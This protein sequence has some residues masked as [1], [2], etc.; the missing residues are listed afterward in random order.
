MMELERLLGRLD[1]DVSIAKGGPFSP[2][3][4]EQTLN[5]LQTL[6][7]TLTEAI[8]SGIVGMP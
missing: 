7:K 2:I 4:K 5:D 8:D 3:Y 6:I 1:S